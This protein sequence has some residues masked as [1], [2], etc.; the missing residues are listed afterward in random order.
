[1]EI[2]PSR[3]RLSVT[4]LDEA[5]KTR[6]SL[7]ERVK[8][9]FECLGLQ[10]NQKFIQAF[11]STYDKVQRQN[12]EIKRVK[13]ELN[14]NIPSYFRQSKC[15]HVVF[16]D[17]TEITVSYKNVVSALFDPDGTAIR[18]AN[19]YKMQQYRLAIA[20]DIT[21]F[22]AFNIQNGCAECK[23]S[24]VDDWDSPMPHVDH[25]G[26]KE[27]RHLV[28]D[29][30]NQTK[31]KDFAKYHRDRAELQMLCEPCNLSKGKS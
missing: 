28:V 29:F 6:K 3:K 31:E 26:N 15:L 1:M 9:I 12:K 2:T 14:E 22:R 5:F 10:H 17:H 4:I 13:Y 18:S 7:I 27:F 30:E 23:I 21:E 20:R 11:V 8:P 19:N 25:C 16:T 24:F